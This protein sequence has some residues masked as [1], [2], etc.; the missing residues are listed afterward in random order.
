[1]F[2]TSLMKIRQLVEKLLENESAH[3][4]DVNINFACKTRKLP[5]R[6]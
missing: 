6:M 5:K 3:E 2:V 1:M 4:R